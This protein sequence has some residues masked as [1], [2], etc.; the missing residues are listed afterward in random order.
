MLKK[1]KNAKTILKTTRVRIPADGFRHSCTR[2]TYRGNLR[3]AH[4][5]TPPRSNPV[6][7]AAW[8]VQL[9]G[10]GG[11]GSIRLESLAE[12]RRIDPTCILPVPSRTQEQ[13]DTEL[14]YCFAWGFPYPK[15]YGDLGTGS[16]ERRQG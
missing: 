3:S 1:S 7:A 6:E 9:G 10:M 12:C 4:G 14:S 13:E 8:G 15:P 16:K 11:L 2:A 5:L